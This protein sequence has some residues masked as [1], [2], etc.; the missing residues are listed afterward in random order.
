[1]N[2]D[3]WQ[4]FA[5]GRAKSLSFKVITCKRPVDD[6]PTPGGGWF[7]WKHNF[8]A[9]LDSVVERAF[10]EKGS[11]YSQ[12]QL[13]ENELRGQ[14][15]PPAIAWPEGDEQAAVLGAPEESSQAIQR[16]MVVG[17][18]E[19]ALLHLHRW[20]FLQAIREMPQNP[21]EHPFGRSVKTVIQ[22]SHALVTWLQTI[23]Q[24]Q[25]A[26]TTVFRLCWTHAYSATMVLGSLV[27][28]CP[29]LPEA[30]T[31]LA[32]LD[33]G[34]DLFQATAHNRTQTRQ[35]LQVLLDLREEA[36]Q[37]WAERRASAAVETLG[38]WTN[39]PNPYNNN[40]VPHEH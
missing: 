17:A 6:E 11:T 5:S 1:M 16:Y 35:S 18:L 34:C 13:L 4:A 32:S 20:F 9:T 24:Y 28:S 36:H 25:P 37:A 26:I 27:V 39:V 29:Q 12:I 10:R 31:A 21:F 33:R 8:T 19:T 38:F 30:E 7:T 15:P 40:S 2:L 23:Y 3:S 22:T 14:S